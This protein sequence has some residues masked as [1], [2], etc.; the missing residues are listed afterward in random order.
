MW[1]EILGLY[2]SLTYLTEHSVLEAHPCCCKRPMPFLLPPDRTPLLTHTPHTDAPSLPIR[3]WVH[4]HQLHGF[5]R[6]LERV[7]KLLCASDFPTV[8][9]GIIIVT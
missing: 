8:K 7:T 4:T 6:D 2:L 5:L 3:L 1:H 9:S